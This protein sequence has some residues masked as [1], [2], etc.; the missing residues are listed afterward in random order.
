MN[1]KSYPLL[2]NFILKL[3]IN[4]I[5]NNS[6]STFILFLFVLNGNFESASDI[7]IIGAFTILITR[8]FH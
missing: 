5:V 6:F 4:N 1:L 8:V 7:A 2:N 3:T